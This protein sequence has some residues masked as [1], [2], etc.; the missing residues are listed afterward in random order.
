[1]LMEIQ[2]KELI[3]YGKKLVTEGLTKGT[4]GNLSIFDRENGLMA[5]TPSGI[6][7]FEIKEEDIVIMNLDGQVVEGDK[8]PS[9][10]W[11]MH[12][13]QYQERDDM[14][15]V[16]H[17]HTTYGTVLACLREPLPASHYMVAVA[18]KDV[19]VAD[20]ATYGSK[21]LA[22]NAALAMK[23]RRA[24][25]LANHGILAGAQDLLNAFNIIE[26]VEYCSKIYCV[27]KSM[28]NPI[29]LSDEEMALM[30][31]KFKTYGQRK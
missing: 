27:A 26:E 1:M 9:S 24:V 15:A 7:F 5:I 3:H 17:A 2:R 30:A 25:F 31:E 18:G 4:G 16:I 13:I 19:R 20:Y 8:L 6:D 21:E 28:G 23:D 12:L 22:E 11:Y 29:V 14:D 10:E